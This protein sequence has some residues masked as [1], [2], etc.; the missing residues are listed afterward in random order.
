LIRNLDEN[1]AEA[2]ADGLSLN[3][4]LVEHLIKYLDGE[5]IAQELANTEAWTIALIQNLDANALATALNNALGTAGGQAFV[6]DL[7]STLDGGMIA[8][9]LNNN[10][11]I[12]KVLMD[13]A[14][15]IGLGNTLHDLL[16]AAGVGEPGAFLTDLIGGLDGPMMTR[17]LNNAWSGATLTPAELA[18]LP[19]PGKTFLQCT[20]FLVYLKATTILGDQQGWAWSQIEGADPAGYTWSGPAVVPDPLDVPTAGPTP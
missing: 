8:E 7:L 5:K 14:G 20:W 19:Y 11:G 15:A 13:E 9:A 17:V 6:V 3:P 12:T 1:T 2:V 10:P 4:E 18:D 16:A